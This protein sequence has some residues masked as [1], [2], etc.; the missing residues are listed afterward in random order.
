[1]EN[2]VTFTN[3]VTAAGE[4][5]G[6]VT[7]GNTI[8]GQIVGG[9]PGPAGPNLIN[10][11]T[12]TSFTG[13]LIGNGT[14]VATATA[15]T[16]YLTPTGNGSGLTGIT[17]SQITNLTSD[18]AAKQPLDSDLTALAANATTGLISRTGSGTVASRTITAGSTKVAVTSGDGVAGNPT[19]DVTPANF[20]G[21]PE[22]GV[23]N[24]T[25]DLAAKAPLASP[26]LTGS[27]TA[28]T[29]S[30]ADNSTKL[31][32]T[33]F[34][35]TAI[36][37]AA[38]TYDDVLDFANLAAFPATGAVGILYI[39]NS[40]NFIYRWGGSSYTQVGGGSSAVTS[41][42]GRTG[43]VVATSG[44]YTPAQVGALAATATAG[45]DLTGNYP[46]P[47]LAATAVTP[48]SYTN[49]NITV[50]SKGRLTAASNGSGGSGASKGFVIAMAAALG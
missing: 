48:G 8:S 12:S 11:S 35:A 25:T 40:T 36:V 28:P 17:E 47:T 23:T 7:N 30:S 2:G 4:I 9:P 3:T 16:D 18:L 13:I 46:N 27:P 22:S 5:V 34:V 20:T 45:G 39:D 50:D 49:A 21:I 42:F 33:A 37:N 14:T 41:I 31:A 44:D 24:L 43:A 6:N 32:T 26:A 10:G 29:Q 19:V 1:M 38:T 15:G